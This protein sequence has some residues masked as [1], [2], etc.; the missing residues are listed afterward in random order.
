MGGADDEDGDGEKQNN[1]GVRWKNSRMYTG[2]KTVRGGRRG[3]K[4]V[5]RRRCACREH[6]DRCFN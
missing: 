5:R 4:K 2:K 1:G 6:D 3:K